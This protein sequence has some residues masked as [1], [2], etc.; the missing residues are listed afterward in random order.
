MSE[1]TDVANSSY[2][3]KIIE[4]RLENG[5]QI[6]DPY[7]YPQANVRRAA[8]TESVTKRRRIADVPGSVPRVYGLLPPSIYNSRVTSSLSCF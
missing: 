4:L 1:A 3:E 8:R 2:L 7:L 5:A 6:I